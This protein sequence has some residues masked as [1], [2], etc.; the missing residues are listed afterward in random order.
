MAQGRTR[1]EREEAYSPV[2]GPEVWPLLGLVLCAVGLASRPLIGLLPPELRP[3]PASVLLPVLLSALSG[4][5][6]FLFSLW[7]FRRIPESSFARVGLIANGTIM[8]ITLLAGL[9][10]L[11]IF[12]RSI[13]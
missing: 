12:R 1:L 13:F 9:A 6:G 2:E 3:Y 10:L 8:G 4:T 11:W 7:G 5:L